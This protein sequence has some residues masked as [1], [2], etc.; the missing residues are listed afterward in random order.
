MMWDY[1]NS[2]FRVIVMA[3]SIFGTL[4]FRHLFIK[5]ERIGLSVVG[6]CGLLSVDV[7]WAKQQSP[8]YWSTSFYTFGMILFLTG[9]MVRK[10]RHDRAN[11]QAAHQARE[12]LRSRRKL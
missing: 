11:K 8:F 10:Y 12:Y 7:I 9:L 3:L 1:L 2:G 4:H 5:V 6:S